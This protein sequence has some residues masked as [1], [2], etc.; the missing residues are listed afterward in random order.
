MI[1]M[2]RMIVKINNMMLMMMMMNT[3]MLI[4]FDDDS[5]EV[6]S[7]VPFDLFMKLA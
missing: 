1:I 2:S 4:M 5:H 3:M 6:C 7:K